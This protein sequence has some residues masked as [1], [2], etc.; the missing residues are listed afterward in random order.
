VQPRCS[1]CSR[2]VRRPALPASWQRPILNSK[3]LPSHNLP[4]CRYVGER[5][6]AGLRPVHIFARKTRDGARLSWPP[7]A[8]KPYR[9][10]SDACLAPDPEDRPPSAAVEAALQVR[11]WTAAHWRT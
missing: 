10:L 11:R 4:H 3:E 2:T 7:G 6:W 5:P 8:P 9:R 1:R